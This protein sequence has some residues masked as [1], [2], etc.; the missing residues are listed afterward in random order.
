MPAHCPPWSTP[1]RCC[2][3]SS[4]R[5]RC[6]RYWSPPSS[7]RMASPPIRLLHAFL[8]GNRAATEIWQWSRRTYYPDG[9]IPE[10]GEIFR[11][12]NL[13]ATA[14]Q[15]R[16]G[17][18]Q[19]AQAGQQSCAGHRGRARS[20]LQR[21]YRA[22]H[23]SRR[24]GRWR[25]AEL[26]RSRQLSRPRRS[27]RHHALPGLRHPQKRLLEPGSGTAAHV[28]HPRGGGHRENAGCAA[29]NICT[30]SPRPSSSR[31]TIAMPGSVIRCSPTFPPKDCCRPATPPN[32]PL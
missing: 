25:I 18:T 21:R 9:R 6:R 31:S 14:A 11:Q 27:A 7:S 19:R 29:S 10:V 2:C 30:P 8:I 16:G 28:E 12:P 1:W 17:R 23:R 15:S 5:C 4:A 22:P 3:R 20:V 24:A 13:G 32:A 26:R